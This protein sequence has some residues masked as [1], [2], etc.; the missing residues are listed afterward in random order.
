MT[1]TPSSTEKYFQ[2]QMCS[3]LG[4]RRSALKNAQHTL[5]FRGNTNFKFLA[6]AD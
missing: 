4:S 6:N 1:T 3:L 5:H 2:Q